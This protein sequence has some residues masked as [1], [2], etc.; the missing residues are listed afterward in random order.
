MMS[1]LLKEPRAIQPGLDG[2][3]GSLKS[4]KRIGTF[5]QPL[6]CASG[7]LASWEGAASA[8]LRAVEISKRCGVRSAWGDSPCALPAMNGCTHMPTSTIAAT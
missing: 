1:R 2:L 8:V 4:G 6:C 5:L 7:L 3:R